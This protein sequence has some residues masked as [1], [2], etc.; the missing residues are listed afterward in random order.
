MVMRLPALQ[1][2]ADV[3]RQGLVGRIA[4]GEQRVAAVAGNLMG[5]EEGALVGQFPVQHV[6]VEHHLPIR[7]GADGLPVFPDIADQH[8]VGQQPRIAFGEEF[9]RAAHLA[10]L[11]EGRGDPKLIFL[12]EFLI[13]EQQDQMIQPR[14]IELLHDVVAKGLRQVQLFDLRADMFCQGNDLHHP[15]P[16]VSSYVWLAMTSRRISTAAAWS[17]RIT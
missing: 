4:A 7:Q 12:A 15:P 6:V 8:D 13:P 16:I 17:S 10:D 1:R 5:I 14:L 9:R 11:A 2:F 3:V